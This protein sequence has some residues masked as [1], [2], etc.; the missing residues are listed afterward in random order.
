MLRAV[1]CRRPWLLSA[2]LTASLA[3]AAACSSASGSS[4][5]PAV[6]S[7]GDRQATPDAEGEGDG[8]EDAVV[9]PVDSSLPPVDSSAPVDSGAGGDDAAVEAS[10]CVGLGAPCKDGTTCLCGEPSGC[11]WDN[12]ACMGGVCTVTQSIPLDAGETCC[13]ECQATYDTCTPQGDACLTAWVTCN[14]ACP[15][16]GGACPV[17]CVA[18]M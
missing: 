3:F 13:S 11:I 12:V 14:A 18:G 15:G 4:S 7:G 5:S 17:V 2:L 6:D 1:P 9:T 16:G 8:G 10:V